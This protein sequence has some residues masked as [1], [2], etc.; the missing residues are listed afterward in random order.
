MI[1]QKDADAIMRA[2]QTAYPHE[3][4]GLLIGERKNACF[5]VRKIMPMT[6]AHRK[7][8]HDRFE[9]APEDLIIAHKEARAEGQC[10]IG[11]YH[12]HPNG[13]PSPS[14]QDIACI[15]DVGALWLIQATTDQGAEALNGFIPRPDASGFKKLDVIISEP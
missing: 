14:D 3:A 9:I 7:R 4:C 8:T 11:H 1:S 10:V 6:N 15:T 2:G 12:S 5:E 13:N